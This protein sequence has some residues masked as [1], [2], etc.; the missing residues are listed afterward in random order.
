M[1][2]PCIRADGS[3]GRPGTAWNSVG[4]RKPDCESE[5]T[6]GALG[7]FVPVR[8][9]SVSP[10]GPS[11]DKRGSATARTAEIGACLDGPA[12]ALRSPEMSS[13]LT[14]SL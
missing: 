9:V 7:L 4:C 13:D 1:A 14:V 11:L 12:L 6:I 3:L 2:S 8:T 5:I 10:S